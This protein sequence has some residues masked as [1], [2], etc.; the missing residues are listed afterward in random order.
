MAS[1]E[2]PI[3]IY[4]LL[5][6]D[7][8]EI[9]HIGRTKNLWRRYVLHLTRLKGTSAKVAWLKDLEAKGRVP[10]VHV[11]ETV[12]ADEAATRERYWITYWRIQRLRLVNHPPGR[13]IVRR[14]VYVPQAMREKLQRRA[15]ARGENPSLLVQEALARWLAGEA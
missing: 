15:A 10:G 2:R 1:P 12:A 9:R 13:D 4:A 3:I 7:T 5:D 8:G 6:P 14:T 11:F